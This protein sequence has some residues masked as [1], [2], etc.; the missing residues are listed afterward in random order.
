ML[1][2]SKKTRIAAVA[3]VCWPFRL[4]PN[5]A[6]IRLRV[7]KKRSFRVTAHTRY[8]DAASRTKPGYDAVIRRTWVTAAGNN[9]AFKTAADRKKHGYF[10]QPRPYTNLPSLCTTV[11]SPS[12]YDVPFSHNSCVTDR[13][14]TYRT[15]GSI[16][17]STKD[18]HE[19]LDILN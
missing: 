11:P 1:S 16:Q 15:Q 6:Y 12:S 4:Y 18:F 8:S 9:I 5:F 3:G 17:R 13:Q 19:S 10:W 14:T 7:A 2:S